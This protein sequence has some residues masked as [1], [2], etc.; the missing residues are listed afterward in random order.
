MSDEPRT[1]GGIDAVEQGADGAGGGDPGGDDA[2]GA[3]V[4]VRDLHETAQRV[5]DAFQTHVEN[6]S[7]R[8]ATHADLAEVL[9]SESKQNIRNHLVENLIPAGAVR[10]DRRETVEYHGQEFERNVYV[11][12]DAGVRADPDSPLP[13]SVDPE[14]LLAEL[15]QAKA[16]RDEARQARDALRTRLDEVEARLEQLGKWADAY[17]D[18]NGGPPFTAGGE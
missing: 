13:S 17:T 16:E 12:T 4:D 11:L 1:D 7:D 18:E 5:L 15:R 8:E 9:P 2:P 10:L 3:P 14:E 6:R